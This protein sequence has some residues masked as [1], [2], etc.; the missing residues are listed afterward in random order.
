MARKKQKSPTPFIMVRKDLLKDKEWQEL[1]NSA[2]I[3]YIYLRG[4][5][6]HKTLSEVSLAYSEVKFM[7]TSTISR[8]FKILQEKGFVEKTKKGGLFGGVTTYR[9]IGKYK[10]F[11]YRG[12][13]I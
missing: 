1:P 12:F 8:G 9:F 2:K 5:F 11:Y 3:L 10:D 6:N 4:K 7:N 13:S